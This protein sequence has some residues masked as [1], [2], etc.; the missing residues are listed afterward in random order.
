MIVTI[1]LALAGVA[2]A[3][4]TGAA[5]NPDEDQAGEIEVQSLGER[6]TERE[7]E[8]RVEEPFTIELFGSPLSLR[9]QYEI[10]LEA[11]SRVALGK[12]SARDKQ[13]QLDQELELEAFYELNRALSFFAQVRPGWE[14]DF[15]SGQ[16]DFFVERG[17]FW[18]YARR[19]GGSGFSLDVGRLNFEDDR[20]WWWDEELDAIRLIYET[21]RF[22]LALAAAE[23]L[24][25]ARFDQR[26][27]APE[28]E[29]VFRLLAEISWDWRAEQSVQFFALYQRDHSRRKRRGDLVRSSREDEIRCGAPLV[30]RPR[31]GRVGSPRA[32][33]ARVLAGCGRSCRA[34]AAGRDGGTFARSTR[35]DG[36]QRRERARS[37][38]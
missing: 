18:L 29:K 19:I 23:E 36:R 38:L 28:D 3:D 20:R 25:P 35:S 5:G 34:R 1:L 2:R 37:G 32:R 26:S 27:I 15:E 30:W 16:T 33:H 8:T 10:A 11:R 4:P 12:A 22:E 13:L 31:G 14:E 7:D 21:D 17:E 9:G 24:L 6:L